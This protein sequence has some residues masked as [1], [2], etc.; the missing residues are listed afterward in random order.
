MAGGWGRGRRVGLWPAGAAAPVS[1]GEEPELWAAGLGREPG[2]S[3]DW[4][5][6]GSPRAGAVHW[7]CGD[8][9]WWGGWSSQPLGLPCLQDMWPVWGDTRSPWTQLTEG[10]KR[11]AGSFSLLFIFSFCKC[12]LNVSEILTDFVGCSFL[13]IACD[14]LAHYFH[15]K[16]PGAAKWE[17]PPGAEASPTPTPLS[18]APNHAPDWERGTHKLWQYAPLLPKGGLGLHTWLFCSYEIRMHILPARGGP[19]LLM[20][21]MR[22][23][24]LVE[25][26]SE[27]DL[28]QR[29]HLF[30]LFISFF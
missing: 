24:M 14:F 21:N 6:K 27:W 30:Q 22:L 29:H 9:H 19:L 10:G 2:L 13:F 18:L 20:S 7:G 23:W 15:L 25:P 28:T 1:Q 11:A 16:Q 17:W 12:L 3:R 26:L 8:L 5:L 4:G